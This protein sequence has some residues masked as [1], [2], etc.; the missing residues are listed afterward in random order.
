MLIGKGVDPADICLMAYYRGQIKTVNLISKEMYPQTK[1]FTSS[2]VDQAQGQTKSLAIIT[3]GASAFNNM[4]SL[5]NHAVS[6]DLSWRISTH[7][8]LASRLC[9]ALTRARH[10][11]IVFCN[12]FSL[13]TALDADTSMDPLRDGFAWQDLLTFA[14]IKGLIVRS[15]MRDTNPRLGGQGAASRLPSPDGSENPPSSQP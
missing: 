12:A 6:N 1:G 14:E 10:G 11:T 7:A 4:N 8:K 15:N 2:T 13:A 9:V 5:C 3:V